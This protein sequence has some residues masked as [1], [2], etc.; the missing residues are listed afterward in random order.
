L[1]TGRIKTATSDPIIGTFYIL[2]LGVGTL[3]PV[4]IKT[5]TSDPII[6]TFYILCFGVGTL[7]PVGGCISAQLE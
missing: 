5:A 3:A 7:A 1:Q 6:G 4:G 2:C